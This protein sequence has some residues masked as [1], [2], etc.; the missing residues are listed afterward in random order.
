MEE[1]LKIMC[2]FCRK[3]YTA[4]M[5]QEFWVASEEHPTWGYIKDV[6]YDISIYCDHCGKLVYQKGGTDR[7]NKQ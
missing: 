2:P 3:Q 7:A 5:E 1:E 6:T 4:R